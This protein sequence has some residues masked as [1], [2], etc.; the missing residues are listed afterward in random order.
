M[1]SSDTAGDSA[2]ATRSLS[3]GHDERHWRD[4]IAELG[5]EIAHPL[6]TALERIHALTSSGRIDRSGLK[7]LRD[8]VEAARQV[9]MTAQLLARFANER[10]QQS[11]ER[12]ALAE[13]LQSV[14]THRKRETETRGIT[15]QPVLQPVDV[16]VDASL[17]FSLLNTLLDWAL[18]QAR[19][20]I[21]FTIDVQSWKSKVRLT[22]RFDL[23]A[24]AMLTDGARAPAPAPLDSLTWRL[25]EQTTA[26]MNLELSRQVDEGAVAVTLKFAAAAKSEVAGI[27]TIDL[28]EGFDSSINSKPLAGSH[29]VVVAS[30]REVRARVRDAIR[31]M[32]LLVDLVGSIEEAADFCRDGLP[33]AL[34]I[35]SIL[36]GERCDRFC[37]EIRAEVPGFPFIDIIEQGQ[38]FSV[39]NDERGE[40]ARVGQEAIEAALPSVLMFELSKTL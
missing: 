28:D 14:L 17:T 8:E 16:I 23:P 1:G 20:R 32:G 21:D 3:A 12:V 33:H 22:C 24:S 39:S 6:T 13:S 36:H 31:N 15:L 18:A 9:G 29:V 7:A 4:L 35:E 11:H 19:S 40:R 10:L 38:E 25:L 30:R 37:A 5:A 2:A 27:T 26:T 34:I